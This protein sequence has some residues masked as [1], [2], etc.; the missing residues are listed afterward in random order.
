VSAHDH[1][2]LHHD[3]A[4]AHVAI[5]GAAVS[6]LVLV[7]IRQCAMPLL[8][9]GSST[10]STRTTSRL[11]SWLVQYPKLDLVKNL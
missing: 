3:T 5:S 2:G 8:Q 7:P 4:E 11:W 10:G 9:T 6:G 1:V